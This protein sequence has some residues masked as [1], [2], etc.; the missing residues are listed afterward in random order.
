MTSA[1][2]A[3]RQQSYRER[4]KKL[5]FT[6]IFLTVPAEMAPEIKAIAAQFRA[7]YLAKTE[8]GQADD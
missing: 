4:M 5:G 8:D 2:N 7:D 3:E 6:Q 1:T